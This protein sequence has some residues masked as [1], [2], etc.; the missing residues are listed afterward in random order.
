LG[1]RNS[2][3][4]VLAWELHWEAGWLA[5]DPTSGT[6][7]GETD[8]VTLTLATSGLLPGTHTTSVWVDAP[9]A[10]NAPRAVKVI[11]HVNTA[12]LVPNQYATIQAA[13]DAAESGD[14]VVIAD[15]V[16]S[17]PGN[18]VL[19]TA[20][21]CITVCSAS[22]DPNTCTIDCQGGDWGFDFHT[23]VRS[24][25]V[26]RGL[27][28][29][30]ARYGGVNCDYSSPTLVDCTFTGN[31]GSS[32]GVHFNYYSRP[33]LIHCT[34]TDN[35]GSGG[36]VFCIANSSPTLTN[37]TITRNG[38]GGVYC[39][40]SCNPV[41][42][43]CL[44]TDNAGAHGGGVWCVYWSS[45]TFVN[46][47]ITGNTGGYGG[48]VYCWY[49][50]SPTLTNCIITDN[51]GG[52]GGGVYCEAYSGPT[53]TNCTITDNTG[54]NGAGVYCQSTSSPAVINCI[55]WGDTPAEIHVESGSPVV[56]YCDVQG[57]WIG[58]GPAIQVSFPRRAR[59]IWMATCVFGTATATARRSSIWVRTSS[60]RSPTAT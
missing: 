14:D 5:A 15:G 18:H 30:N 35:T 29:R 47:L 56:S 50:C 41:L 20:G 59:P 49:N 7:A 25:A 57:G 40:T 3:L 13:I 2:S 8:E 36:G 16:Y 33:Q 45:P 1:I 21:K 28:I 48:G 39:D 55:L 43:D 11:L 24:D 51:A 19:D 27:T 34:I 44:I 54:G 10:F 31:V 37:C 60:A 38:G 12:R 42:I 53:L 58:T 46:C 4:G 23:H 9:S 32:T 22:G 52:H 17:G 6:S 26:V